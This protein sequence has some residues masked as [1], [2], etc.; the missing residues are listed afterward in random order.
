ML[1]HGDELGRS[2]Q[3][4]NNTYAQDSEIAWMHWDKV[5]RPL[6]EFTR[7]VSRLRAEHPTFRRK[8]FFTG[9]TVRTGEGEGERLNDI[10]WLHPDGHP[11]EAGDWE[12]EGAKA[13]GM[14]LNGHGIA[15]LDATGNRIVD[16]HFLLYFNGGHEDVTVVLPHDEY[17]A[18]WDE[19]IDTAGAGLAEE[20]HKAG[21]EVT[22]Y[23][24]SVLVLRE[25]TVPD[26]EPDSSVAA[27]LFAYSDTS[28]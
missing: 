10:V 24:R 7:A 16:D 19:V 15:G 14:Y 11:M 6:V 3:G 2:Q 13:L 17:A 1:L 22:L 21:A 23:A 28:A 20:P 12:A 8:R 5:D 26:V 4:N 18:A 27:S 25:H 9:T